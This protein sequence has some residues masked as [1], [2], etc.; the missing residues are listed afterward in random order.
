M[1]DA[2]LRASREP[3]RRLHDDHPGA[4]PWPAPSASLRA[5][6]RRGLLEH[7]ERRNRHGRR[8]EEWTVTDAGLEALH[9]PAKVKRDTPRSLRVPGGSTMPKRARA[10]RAANARKA[11]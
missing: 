10:R 7:R 2:L 11:A 8:V 4:P 1:R 5:L 3:L 9:P 6:V